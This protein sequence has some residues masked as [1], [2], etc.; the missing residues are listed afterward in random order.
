MIEDQVND[1]VQLGETPP[2]DGRS[3]TFEKDFTKTKPKIRDSLE[4][5]DINMLDQNAPALISLDQIEPVQPSAQ[6]KS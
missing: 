5:E 4:F 1:H 2:A 3:F 6:K